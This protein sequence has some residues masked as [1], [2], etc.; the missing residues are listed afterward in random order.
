VDPSNTVEA[1]VQVFI[2]DGVLG[3]P[4]F[5]NRGSS[6][7]TAVTTVTET[8]VVRTVSGITNANPG[9]VTTSTNH[10][11]TSGQ[12]VIFANVAGMFQINSGVYY[13]VNVL[14]PNTFSLYV[15]SALTIPLNTTDYGIYI[16][17]LGTVTSHLSPQ[18]TLKMA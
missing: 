4:T 1:P 5:T 3:Q 6:F 13:Y 8:G 11:Y 16:A 10:T 7:L 12:K 18:T 17:S 9:V 2:G 15:D 14:T